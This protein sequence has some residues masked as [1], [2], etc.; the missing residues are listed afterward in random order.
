MA[1]HLFVVL[2]VLLGRLRMRASGNCGGDLRR[3]ARL[4]RLRRHRQAHPAAER[5]WFVSALSN[6]LR[7]ILVKCSAMQHTWRCGRLLDAHTHMS[8]WQRCMCEMSGLWISVRLTV[9]D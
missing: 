8:T 1:T 3:V 5:G 7:N 9:S 6:V 4:L 2:L